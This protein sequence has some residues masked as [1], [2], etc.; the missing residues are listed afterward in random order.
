MNSTNILQKSVFKDKGGEEI[1][2]VR[3]NILECLAGNRTVVGIRMRSVLINKEEEAER[4]EVPFRSKEGKE[5]EQPWRK[6]E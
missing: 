4:E 3:K 6:R 2:K 5:G 1:N